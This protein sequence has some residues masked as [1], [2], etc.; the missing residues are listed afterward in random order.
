M[1]AVSVMMGGVPLDVPARAPLVGRA[2]ELAR[3]ARLVGV[4]EPGE[5]GSADARAGVVLLSGEAG[6][7]KTRLL[8]ALRE[9]AT[10]RGWRVAVGHGVDLGDGAL[11]YLPFSEA[12]GRLD[13]D[14][15]AL[16]DAVTAAHPAVRRLVPGRRDPAGADGGREGAPD[17]ERPPDR[18]ELFESVHAALHD[19]GA[20]APLLLVLEDVHWADRS[21]RD[22]LSFLLTRR[23]TAPVSLVASYRSDDLHRRHPLRTAVARWVRFAGV[24]RLD[25]TPLDDGDVRTLVRALHPDPLREGDVHALVARAEGN[26]FFAEELVAAT[27]LDGGTVP[28]DLA[29]LLLVRL[30]RLDEAARH[31]V[32]AASAAGRRVSHD[33]LS[34]VVDV[35]G[36]AFDGAA[37]DGAVRAAVEGHVL[38][39]TRLDGYAFRHALLGEA[40][41]DDLLPGERVRLHTAYVRALTARE[42]AGTA[43]ELAR[44]ARAAH[45]TGTALSASVLAGDEAAAVGGPDEALR[46]YELALELVDDQAEA[47]GLTVR[48]SAA[49]TAAGHLQQAV[50]LVE[51]R[52]RRTTADAAP[53]DR[54]R[55]LHAL[56]RA[57]IV[58]DL[59]VDV[60]GATTEALTLVPDDPPS[61]LR[62]RVLGVHAEVLAALRRDEDAEQR[63]EEALTLARQLGLPDVVADV[64]TTLARVQERTGDPDASRVTLQRIIDEAHATGDPAELRGL[65][66]LGGLHYQQGR[67]A[68]AWAVYRRG[69]ERARELGRQWAP[70]GLDARVLSALLAYTCGDWDAAVRAVDVSGQA[71]PP[72]AEAALTAVRLVVAAGR[73][74]GEAR[75]RVDGVRAWWRTDGLIA[76][77]SGGAEI[78]LYGDAGDLA[79]ARAAYDDVVACIG[80]LWKRPDFEARIRLSGLLLAQVA[81]QASRVGAPER[82]GLAGWGDDLLA[83]ARRAVPVRE[84]RRVGPESRAWTARV[85][86]EHLRLRWLTGV[87]APDEERLVA[88]WEDAVAAFETFPHVFELARSRTRLTAVLRAA[89]RTADAGPHADAAREVARRLGA[90]PLLAELQALGRTTGVRRDPDARH[91]ESLTTRER[92]VLT[93]VA[94]GRSNREIAGRLFISPKTVSVHVSNVLA[95]LGAAGRTEAVAVARRR[96]LL[97]D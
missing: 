43:A 83:A 60:L 3:L 27:T 65:H 66:H 87:D 48:A 1:S 16:M 37:F 8:R 38:V 81:A 62:V 24:A 93:L 29:G 11:P 71:P 25:L 17:G 2:D 68:E 44:H 34:Q 21:T 22:L 5:P 51:D 70:Y 73:G 91:D 82:R 13:A 35:D 64:T 80:D 85:E 77:L 18:G 30:D 50:A 58:S 46:H 12:F 95:K 15:P 39:P 45:D 23:F 90:R 67:V 94:E 10:E 41:Y 52:L 33:V 59:E 78:D 20:D 47:V 74:E 53:A 42:G 9:R 97:G 56:A 89:G 28:R 92:E 69:A 4:A 19:V 14:A 32:R 54:A 7:G 76:I 61:P 84:D 75:S 63:G 36:P 26:A 6:I 86:A 40:V 88:A 79:G 57:A 72:M 96:G 31:V 49:A 55:L